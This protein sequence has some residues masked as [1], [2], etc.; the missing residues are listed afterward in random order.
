MPAPLVAVTPPDADRG[1]WL[2]ARSSR[3]TASEINRVA[4]GGRGTWR[5]ILAD[6]LNGAQFRGNADTQR[7]RDREP[8]LMAYIA[9]FVEPAIKPNSQLFVHPDHSRIGAT[10]DGIGE[11]RGTR[12][13]AEVKSHRFGWDRTDVPPQHFDQIQLQLAVCGADRCLYLW[14]SMGEDGSPTLDDPG[15]VWVGRDEKRIDYLIRQAE[16]FLAWWDAGAPSEDD[17][18]DDLDDALARWAEARARKTAADDDEAAAEERIRAYIAAVP[19]A[20]T[21]G[22]K[23]AGRAA[24]FVYSVKESQVLDEEAW[25]RAQPESY[26]N[27][28]F[29]RGMLEA[30]AKTAEQIFYKTKQSTRLTITPSKEKAA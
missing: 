14:E 19:S 9:S 26:K 22:L 23:L 10:P 15:H 24:S 3:V 17:L 18:P 4:S 27:W 6:K 25:E 2:E 30:R 21:E 16:E 13:L 8:A 29:F 11:V 5:Q 1:L 12:V 20:N 28:T 7:G